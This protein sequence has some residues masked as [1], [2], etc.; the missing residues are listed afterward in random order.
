MFSASK[1]IDQVSQCT[2][3]AADGECKKNP[4]WMRPNCP[5]SCELCAPACIDQL[6]QCPEWVADGECTKNPVWMR[7][8]CPVSCDLC[9]KAVKCADTFPEDCVN[10]KTAG[11]C[12]DENRIWMFFNCPKT[13][14]TC[15][16]KFNG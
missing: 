7:P 11:H 9:G 14:W 5:V 15:G 2:E 6:S 12:K 10:W 1:C 13:C 4:V 16:I 8:N 3:W